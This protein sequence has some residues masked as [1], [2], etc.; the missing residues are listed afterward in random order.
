MRTYTL[1][2]YNLDRSQPLVTPHENECISLHCPDYNGRGFC[3][4]FQPHHLA[5]IEQL[6]NELRRIAE[7]DT[8]K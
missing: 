8:T 4:I 5:V 6:A 3:L 2:T 1:T 7:P